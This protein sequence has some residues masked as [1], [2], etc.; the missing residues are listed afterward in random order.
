MTANS[1]SVPFSRRKFIKRAALAGAAPFILPSRIWSAPTSPNSQITVASIGVGIQG[2]GLLGGCLGRHELRVLAVCDVDSTRRNSAKQMVEDHYGKG[3]NCAAYNDFRELVARKD[4]DAVVIAT[5][6]HWHAMTSIAALKSGK[7]VYCEKPLSH[8]VHEGRAMVKAARQHRR[9]FQ[10]GSM[11]RSMTEFRAA[12]ELVRN[13]V[14]GTIGHAE[15]RIAG[16]PVRC[17]LPEERAEPGLDWNFWLGGAPY[18]PYNSI[19]SPR[20]VYTT[21]FPTGE[22][23]ANTAPAVWAIG[24]RTILTS[25][26][27]RLGFDASG[28]VEFLPAAEPMPTAA[29]ASATASGVEVI[30]LPGN[31]VT[32]YGS[33]GKIYV[34]RGQFKFWLGDKLMT[35]DVKES[36]QMLDDHLPPNSDPALSQHATIMGDW[37]Q[38]MHTRQKPICDVEIGHRTATICELVNTD[39]LAPSKAGLEPGPRKVP[40]SCRRREVAGPGLSQALAFVLTVRA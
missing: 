28:P 40:R 15:V 38:C 27:G 35:D 17:D 32:F 36:P 14:I 18:R 30:H 39:L 10:T 13:G 26:N 24:A 22:N 9:V 12:C 8:T 1:S 4:I 29:C 33:A 7:D 25:C 20:G 16:P 37:I 19:L 21:F 2:R 5:P 34:N 3:A 6:D 31:G 11:Q 23:T